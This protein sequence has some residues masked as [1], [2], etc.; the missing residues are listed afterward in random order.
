[1]SGLFLYLLLGE[2]VGLICL[3][4]GKVVV[5]GDDFGVGMWLLYLVEYLGDLMYWCYDLGMVV[6]VFCVVEDFSYVFFLID[7]IVLFGLVQDIVVIIDYSFFVYVLI[8]QFGCVLFFLSFGVKYEVVGVLCVLVWIGQGWYVGVVWVS[9]LGGGCSVFVMVYVCF[10]WQQGFGQMCV[11]FWFE[12][13][14]LVVNI[15]YLQD[16]GLVDGIFVYYLI[17]LEFL[18]IDGVWIVYLELYELFEENFLLIFILLLELV[19]YLVIICVCD[20]LVDMF[21]GIVRFD[22]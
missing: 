20:N 22:I 11:W 17:E 14:W 7:V 2:D 10:D 16:I 18:D 12:I 15:C 8:F 4:F 13:G 9:V 6:L 1:M 5:G 19:V 21:I 3:V